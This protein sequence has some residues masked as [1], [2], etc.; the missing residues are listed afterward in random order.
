MSPNRFLRQVL[1]GV[2]AA[3]ILFEEWLWDPLKRIMDRFGRLPVV[4]TLADAISGLPSRWALAAYLGPM[5]LLVP[6]K[7]GALW[8]IAH[9]H[10]MLGLV[11]FLAAKVVGTALFAW[12]FGLTRPALMTIPWFATAYRFV[13]DTGDRARAWIRSQP[14]YAAMLRAK[15][16]IRT[17]LARFA[18]SERG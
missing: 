17:R 9:G 5:V 11:I 14:L 6:F 3:V 2:A 15:N 18:R 16:A 8:M 1:I 7:V 4:R 12:L 10:S 13:R